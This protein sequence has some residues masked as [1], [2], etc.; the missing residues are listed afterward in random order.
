[1]K[2]DKREAAK[3]QGKE[4]SG[5]WPAVRKAHLK[6]F[7]VCQVCSGKKNLQVHHKRPFHL[8]PE[9]ELD[10]KN[11]I[12]LCEHGTDCHI[13]FGHA[14]DFKGYNPNVEADAAAWAAKF[15]ESRALAGAHDA[16]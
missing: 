12:T 11:L 15:R 2:S 6:L 7:P 10:P 1:M 13:V 16:T 4:R 5:H 3:T 14:G 9:L 8:H